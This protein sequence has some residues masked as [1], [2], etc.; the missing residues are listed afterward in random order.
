MSNLESILKEIVIAG[1]NAPAGQKDKAAS[2]V[3]KKYGYGFDEIKPSIEYFLAYKKAPTGGL[4]ARGRELAGGAFLEFG[5]ELEA[6]GTSIFSDESYDEVV[7]RIRAD[8][9]AFYAMN[10]AETIALNI[11]GGVAMP[12]GAVGLTARGA[13]L[14]ST[15]PVRTTALVGAGQGGLTGVGLVDD[16]S[17]LRQVATSAGIGTGLGGTVGA[18]GGKVSTMLA[19]R[20]TDEATRGLLKGRQSLEAD[21]TTIPQIANRIRNNATQDRSLNITPQEILADFGGDVT[22]RAL[23]GARVASPDASQQIDTTLMNRQRGAGGLTTRN[24]LNPN[25]KEL[26]QGQRLQATINKVADDIAKMPSGEMVEV[27]SQ[28]QKKNVLPKYN[29]TVGEIYDTA[30]R[31]NPVISD[32]TVLRMLTE[33]KPLRNS[34]KYA[35]EEMIS[36]LIREKKFK[37]ADEFRVLVPENI[38]DIMSGNASLSLEFLDMVKRQVGDALWISN[39]NPTRVTDAPR[40]IVEQRKDLQAFTDALKKASK[41]DEYQDVLKATADQFDISKAELIGRNLAGKS[42]KQIRE[43]MKGMNSTQLDAL[44]LG[45]LD[46]VINKIG[47]ARKS[48]DKVEAV[49]GGENMDEVLEVIFE[50]QPDALAKFLNR[51]EREQVMSQTKRTVMGNSSTADKLVDEKGMNVGQAVLDASRVVSGNIDRDTMSRMLNKLPLV[52]TPPSTARGTADILTTQGVKNQFDV[53]RRMQRLN[54][55]LEKINHRASTRA[56]GVPYL[57][58]YPVVNYVTP[59]D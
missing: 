17:D 30:Y 41:G 36:K 22:R 26:S 35:R 21:G 15:M 37:E 45:Y 50:G 20:N 59:E 11:L 58:T 48:T 29:K 27:L 6:F 8:R 32:P 38:D 24:P 56:A 55:T 34:Y 40:K 42:A 57:S 13:K 5:D 14:A 53:L 31:N 12:A 3:A 52:G 54:E 28:H 2:S 18:L 25:Q 4:I 1:Q 47:S 19:N 10:P 43:F 51:I 44:R 9:R 7:D 49:V 39:R 46:T 33:F 23:R 16:K